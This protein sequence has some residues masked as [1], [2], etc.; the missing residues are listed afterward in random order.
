MYTMSIWAL[1]AMILP[2]FRVEE[3]WVL[4]REMVPWVGVALILLAAMMLVEALR[5]MFGKGPAAPPEK[6]TA[7][8][9]A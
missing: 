1:V 6:P 7:A 4:P 2:K 5:A 8:L 9:A 3:Q